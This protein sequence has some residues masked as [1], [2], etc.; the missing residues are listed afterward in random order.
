MSVQGYLNIFSLRY[1]LLYFGINLTNLTY[2]A[3][4]ITYHWGITANV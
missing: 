1:Y 2:E 4:S 3:V